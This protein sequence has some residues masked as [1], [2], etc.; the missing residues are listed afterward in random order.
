MVAELVWRRTQVLRWWWPCCW[1][2]ILGAT[3]GAVEIQRVASRKTSA[4]WSPFAVHDGLLWR[5]LWG[6]NLIVRSNARPS[7]WST[8]LSSSTGQTSKAGLNVLIFVAGVDNCPNGQPS[9]NKAT[10]NF[11]YVSNFASLSPSLPSELCTTTYLHTVLPSRSPVSLGSP[12]DYNPC[13]MRV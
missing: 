2:V 6:R 12:N 4:V 7:G 1:V 5:R 13:M 8:T 9:R 11:G 10:K 3:S